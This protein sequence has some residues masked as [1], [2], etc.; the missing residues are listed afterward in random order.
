VDVETVIAVSPRFSERIRLRD[1][2]ERRYVA[3]EVSTCLLMLPV[4]Y[5]LCYA[6]MVIYTIWVL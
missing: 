1:L 5:C 6:S 2:S 4:C 3:C